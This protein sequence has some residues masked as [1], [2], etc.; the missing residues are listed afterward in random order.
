MIGRT[1][2]SY[3]V[4]SE[5][6]R[7][8]MGVV[9][10]A[11]DI[12]LGR[13]VALKFLP[14]PTPDELD[15]ARFLQEARAASQISHPNVCVVHSI[16]EFEG[17]P[18]I[19]MEFVDGVTL[20]RKLQSGP[21]EEQ[22]VLSWALAISDALQEAHSRGVVHRDI[23]P[24]NIMVHGR[25]QVKVMDFGLAKL[26]GTLK[27][28]RTGTTVGTLSYMAPEVIQRAVSDER[29]DLFSLGVML[30]E[31]LTG[32]R[33]FRGDHEGA[34]INAILTEAPR[35]IQTPR[36]V[37]RP[38]WQ[39]L[40]GHLLEKDP[41]RRVSSAHDVVGELS[42]I[43]RVLA[44]PTTRTA[45]TPRLASSTVTPRA[46]IGVPIQVVSAAGAIIALAIL[47]MI[48]VHHR[49]FQLNP[50]ARFRALRVPAGVV[51]YPGMSA[52]GKWIAFGAGDDREHMDLYLMNAMIGEP[53]PITAGASLSISSVDVSKDGSEIAYVAVT[54]PTSS[55]L[56]VLPALGGAGK[57]VAENAWAPHWSPEGGRIGFIVAGAH[58]ASRHQELWSVSRDGSDARREFADSL[59]LTPPWY[60]TS[61]SWSPDGKSVVWIRN[62]AEGVNELVVRDLTNG[63][64]RQLTHDRS[65]IDDVNWTS[66]NEIVFAS[67]RSGALNLWVVPSYGGDPIQLT[68]GS[69][70]DTGTCMSGD[71]KT[72][73]YLQSQT[74]GHL[75]LADLDRGEEQQVTR[76]ELTLPFGTMGLS[77]SPDNRRVAATVAQPTAPLSRSL[78][79]MNRDGTDRQEIL[80]ESTD[81]YLI[82]WSPDGR[83]LAYTAK[84]TGA[85]RDSS[86]LFI[87]DGNRLSNPRLLHRDLLG[88]VGWLDSTRIES[89]SAHPLGRATAISIDG[90]ANVLGISDSTWIL[91]SADAKYAVVLDV[92]SGHEG[93]WLRTPAFGR[94]SLATFK[95][96]GVWS[97]YASTDARTRF[98]IDVPTR[99]RVTRVWLP[100]L[101][102]ETLP[103]LLPHLD[104]FAPRRVS[105]DGT[106]L[107]YMDP[108][109]TSKL[110]LVENLRR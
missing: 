64:E 57:L 102:V 35:Q 71:G 82:S 14:D 23:K 101:R 18:F 32:E 88:V 31:M 28:T 33:P 76:E 34:V 61:F 89:W 78:I 24:E 26:R 59:S 50:G 25:G 86:D 58:S 11:D 87:M 99:Q 15:R 97:G 37:A 93:L 105:P 42:R 60:T 49:G 48:A 74:T 6:G 80:P 104:R 68:R 92:R 96:I 110:M 20:R 84:R 53:R 7:G 69:G 12:R 44:L 70:P 16:E 77:I 52:D 3:R 66:Q 73:L 47:A 54:G 98:L 45:S 95:P 79:V 40:I 75:W 43:E 22:D 65:E 90:T 19:V 51:S 1:I 21:L 103:F 2:L 10:L 100:S 72:L 4:I 36:L 46:K 8:G 109:E 38:E 41:E 30:Y 39:A 81:P 67:N 83:W 27:L 85:P 5:I 29:S 56:R 62:L 94:D 55:E 13:R 91:P 9:Y 107:I 108:H 63:R 17:R 106:H